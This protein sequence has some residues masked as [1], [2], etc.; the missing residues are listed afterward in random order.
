M[1]PTR[2]MELEPWV[3]RHE[4]H[5]AKANSV[6]RARRLRNQPRRYA[7]HAMAQ[8]YR[9]RGGT[10]RVASWHGRGDVASLVL[11]SDRPPTSRNL[12]RL[13]HRLRSAGFREVVTNAL[14]PGTSLPFVD[15]GF[16]VRGR[17]HLL[18]HDLQSVPTFSRRTRRATRGDRDQILRV[19]AA[20]F[21]EFW[22]F[23]AAALREARRAT[24]S[25]RTSVSPKRG[26][27]GAYA[28]FGRAGTAG[29]VQRLAV[30]PTAQGEGLGRALLGD[31]M[32]WMKARG[33]ARALVNT[34]EH[35]ERALAL[36]TTMGFA[37]LPVGLCVLGRAL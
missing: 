28:L 30:A 13:L 24:P 5:P 4:Q 20:A 14:G 29:Y 11:R 6:Q 12:E 3:G 25:S 17:L 36:Y 37:R 7:R 31:G 8:S 23:D 34:Q 33:A 18:E 35:N 1:A 21:D 32:R 16:T 15:A 26:D 9:F 10:A 2:D 22:R 19:D 27:I